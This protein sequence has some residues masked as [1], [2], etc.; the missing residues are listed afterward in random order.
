MIWAGVPVLAHRYDE[1]LGPGEIVPVEIALNPT[2]AFFLKGLK[3][4][5]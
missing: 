5:F 3:P 4:F 2:S 1:K